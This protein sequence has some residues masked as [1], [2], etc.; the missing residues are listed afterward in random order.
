[1][2]ALLIYL[3]LRNH[4]VFIGFVRFPAL[5]RYATH[6]CSSNCLDSRGWSVKHLTILKCVKVSYRVP[7]VGR[8]KFRTCNL[9]VAISQKVFLLGKHDYTVGNCQTKRCYLVS[10]RFR[11]D[12]KY[13]RYKAKHEWTVFFITL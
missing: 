7:F 8:Q 2:T 11:S 6:F 13:R 5:I 4:L 9:S 12:K 1:M 10:V 3:D